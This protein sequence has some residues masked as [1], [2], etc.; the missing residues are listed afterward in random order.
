MGVLLPTNS[1][2]TSTWGKLLHAIQWLFRVVANPSNARYTIV[3]TSAKISDTHEKEPKAVWAIIQGRA[4]S[5]MDLR[6]APR[7]V[8]ILPSIRENSMIT[9]VSNNGTELAW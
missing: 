2:I 5:A 1:R 9:H 7:A 8:P 3:K 4:I 6:P